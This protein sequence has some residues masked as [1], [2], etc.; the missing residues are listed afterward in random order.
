[1]GRSQRRTASVQTR[2]RP[3][4]TREWF[5]RCP[6]PQSSRS[7]GCSSLTYRV[8]VAAGSWRHLRLRDQLSTGRK[9]KSPVCPK[10]LQHP[11]PRKFQIYFQ[12]ESD[13]E[14]RPV[15][16]SQSEFFETESWGTRPSTFRCS[17]TQVAQILKTVNA[18]F[19]PV[20]PAKIQGIAND[21]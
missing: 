4:T 16:R 5:D 20:A 13:G 1:P 8:S 15:H 7:A 19:V 9:P 3:A 17:I 14:F 2:R 10:P 21:N 11:Q 12:S 18:G 6:I